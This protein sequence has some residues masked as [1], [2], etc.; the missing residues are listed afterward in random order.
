MR[1]SG[2]AKKPPAATAGSN[3]A[4]KTKPRSS[5][6][7][8]SSRASLSG[9]SA[10]VE[11]RRSFYDA[12]LHVRSYDSRGAVSVGKVEG[13]GEFYLGLAQHAVGGVLEIG[14]GT[15]RV[16]LK[17]VEAGIS[18]TGLDASSAMLEIAGNKASA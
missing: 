14:V 18:V 17:L 10:N 2:R 16:A 11:K 4:P 9:V 6:G 1:R 8:I 3:P 5:A 7:A 13:D 15:G 12:T